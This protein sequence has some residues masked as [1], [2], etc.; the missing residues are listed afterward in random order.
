[1]KQIK[2]QT[3]HKKKLCR[4]YD[5][6]DFTDFAFFRRSASAFRSIAG[7]EL[8]FFEMHPS[9]GLEFRFENL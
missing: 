7:H 1:M 3:I 2:Q 5:W 4:Y 9:Q 8:Q 6:A